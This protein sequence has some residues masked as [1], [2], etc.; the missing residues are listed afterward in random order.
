MIGREGVHPPTHTYTLTCAHAVVQASGAARELEWHWHSAPM[1]GSPPPAT[2]AFAH[3]TTPDH[4]Y[5]YVH[6]GSSFANRSSTLA[7]VNRLP[8]TALR[9]GNTSSF[10]AMAAAWEALPTSMSEGSALDVSRCDHGMV[11]TQ[12]GSTACHQNRSPA[13]YG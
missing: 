10:A 2:V 3:A 8:L 9:A 1:L 5:V 7:A 12:T 6:G 13:K 4:A 11:V